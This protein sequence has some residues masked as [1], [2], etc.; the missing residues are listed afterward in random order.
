MKDITLPRVATSAEVESLRR[1]LAARDLDVARLRTEVDAARILVNVLNECRS[2]AERE[3][4][5]LR[6]TL[7]QP[8]MAWAADMHSV[9]VDVAAE[10]RRLREELIPLR[11]IANSQREY[12]RDAAGISQLRERLARAEAVYEAAKAW[13]AACA[14]HA[15]ITGAC[16][17]CRRYG[18]GWPCAQHQQLLDAEVRCEEDLCA[19]VALAAEK[20][21]TP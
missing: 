11:A 10:D 9:G 21:R 15:T 13:H 8:H 16:S 3:C 4:E 7:A 6:A 5:K 18:G 17:A 19:A 1:E 14:A 2:G 20:E 12:E